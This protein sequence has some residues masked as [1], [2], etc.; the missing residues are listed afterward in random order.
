VTRNEDAAADSANWAENT[1]PISPIVQSGA[2]E[3]QPLNLPKSVIRRL[4]SK[5]LTCRL[6]RMFGPCR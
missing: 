2:G 5:S 3:I 1:G 6:R 4:L